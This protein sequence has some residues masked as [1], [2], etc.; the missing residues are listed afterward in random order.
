MSLSAVLPFR[1]ALLLPFR[2]YPGRST[3]QELVKGPVSVT[4]TVLTS[5]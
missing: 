5:A 3:N 2:P 4:F 1:S